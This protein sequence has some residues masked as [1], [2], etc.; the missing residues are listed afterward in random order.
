M[1]GAG[2]A[3]SA[4]AFSSDGSILGV[5]SRDE[6]TL[7]EPYTNSMLTSLASPS[8]NQGCPIVKLLFV[9]N[10]PFLAG[11]TTGPAASLIVWN[12]LAEAIWWSY[13][14]TC[15]ALAVDPESSCIAV[16]VA[17]Q[18]EDAEG[19]KGS[20][21]AGA[22]GHKG[23]HAGQV[24][25][26]KAQ[27][28]NPM[29]TADAGSNTAEMLQRPVTV[30]HP[31]GQQASMGSSAVFLF[32]PSSGQPQLSWSLGQATVAALLFALP[33]TKLHSVSVD[34]APAGISPLLILTEDRQYAIAR[35]AAHMHHASFQPSTPL[36]SKQP[37]AFEA[38]F[39]KAAMQQ[40]VQQA[41]LSMTTQS[42]A[43]SQL[44]ALFAAPSHVLPPLKDLAPA[45]FDNLIRHSGGPT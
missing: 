21:K 30:P 26:L 34:V 36:Q 28:E 12:L 37:S 19:Q 38:A 42:Q 35:S 29:T 24:A 6:V 4:A 2:E 17:P 23:S 10:T 27:A 3:M 15:S 1:V 40:P 41:A 8:G 20:Y 33:G 13:A 14:L 32:V 44:E 25:G 22:D 43:Q 11:Y 45:F 39:G 9:P 16:A 7:W 5:A 31:E 18:K